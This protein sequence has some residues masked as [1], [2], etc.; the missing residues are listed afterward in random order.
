MKRTSVVLVLAFTFLIPAQFLGQ[1]QANPKRTNLTVVEKKESKVKCKNIRTISQSPKKV[2]PPTA[3]LKRGPKT[4]TLSTNCGDIVI[5][6]NFRAAPVTL[7]VLSTLMN[8]GYYNRTFCH[9]VTVE[10]IFIL[11]CGDPTGTGAG[12]PGFRYRDENLPT[13]TEGNYAEGTVAMANSGPNTNGSQFFIVYGN[14]TLGPNYTIWGK[15]TSGLEIVKYI[16]SGGVRGGA[17]D[18]R[19]VRDIT[20][21][22]VTV[23]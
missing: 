11:Q 17:S 14:T 3:I 23:R 16:A 1:A 15:V 2:D 22:K 12:D 9:R 7:T 10:E 8:A 13:A 6:T 18:G 20:I 21:E 4:V 19:P 5:Q